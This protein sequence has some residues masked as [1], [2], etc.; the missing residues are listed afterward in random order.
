MNITKKYKSLSKKKILLIVVEI[1]I[2]GGSAV[3]TSTMG[4][5]N[6][7]VRKVLTSGTASL[8]SLAILMTKEYI[9]EW[10][11]RYTKLRDWNNV[12]TLL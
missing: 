11:T 5:I 7:S 3:G 9:S 8:S 12:F 1:L 2:D 10:T 6:P 4:L